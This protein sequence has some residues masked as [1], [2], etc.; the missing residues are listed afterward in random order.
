V[1]HVATPSV[2]GLA[3]PPLNY[4]VVSAGHDHACASGT[5]GGFH[6]ATGKIT[7]LGFTVQCWGNNAFG[8]LTDGSTK[9]SAHP[10]P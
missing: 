10:V 7:G 1:T 5:Y 2:V 8:Q 4:V 9:N 6:K 3:Q